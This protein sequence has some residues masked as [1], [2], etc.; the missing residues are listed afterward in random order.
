MAL[1]AIPTQSVIIKV[2]GADF[3][4]SR[5]SEHVAAVAMLSG[6]ARLSHQAIISQLSFVWDELT[7]RYWCMFGAQSSVSPLTFDDVQTLCGF[8]G[9]PTFFDLVEA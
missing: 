8:Y 3:H 2:D 4:F 5:P 1:T 9:I 6:S 7:N